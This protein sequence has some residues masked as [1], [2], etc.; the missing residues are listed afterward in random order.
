[1]LVEDALF[2]TLDPTT[3]RSQT[4]DGRVFTLTDTVGFVRHLPHD[5]VEA[6]R[7]TLEESTEADL[8][9]HVV[10]ASDPDPVGQINAVRTVLNEIGANDIAEQIVFNKIDLANEADLVP[11]RTV[12]PD[13]LFVSARTGAGLEEL[14]ARIEE[15]L[16][17]PAVEVEA[18][19]PYARHD[20]IDRIHKA[21]EIVSTEHTGEGTLV[22]ARV[23]QDLAGELAEFAR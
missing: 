15:R 9:V 20:L 3:R 10:D 16:P 5:L 14:R 22:R 19:V 8:L 12:A 7:S 2:A 11:L 17:R 21:G 18:L 6:F 1:M 4:A 13:A 23:N